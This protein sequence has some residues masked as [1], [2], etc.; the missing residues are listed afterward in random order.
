MEK[1]M[2]AS[3]LPIL[4]GGLV[5][6]IIEETHTDEDVAFKSLYSSKLYELLENEETK[7]WNFSVPMLFDLYQEEMTTG[8]FMLPEC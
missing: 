3:I 2:F 8:S 5:N 7:V 6:K 1:N 4:V